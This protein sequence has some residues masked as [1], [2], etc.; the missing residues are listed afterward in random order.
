MP[1]INCPDCNHPMSDQAKVCPNC[2]APRMVGNTKACVKCG[3]K[4]EARKKKCPECEAPQYD[5]VPESKSKPA[6][7]TQKT[8]SAGTLIGGILLGIA[9]GVAGLY[10]FNDLQGVP[11]ATQQIDPSYA[12]VQK[13]NGLYVFINS[14]PQKPTTF[15]ETYKNRIVD[16]V[17]D[18]FN[19]KGKNAMDEPNQ[20]IDMVMFDEK[21]DRITSEVLRISTPMQSA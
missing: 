11:A 6:M 2:N 19:T 7:A 9:L 3:A 12:T 18:I 8:S 1:Q 5:S 15:I 4:I 13:K 10:I 20:V 14:R 21:I 17:L 16:Q